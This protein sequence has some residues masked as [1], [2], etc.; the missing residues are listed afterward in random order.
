MV[1]PWKSSLFHK[2]G[3]LIN[4]YEA[5]VDGINVVYEEYVLFL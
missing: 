2:G 4:D 5:I 3:E 1:H